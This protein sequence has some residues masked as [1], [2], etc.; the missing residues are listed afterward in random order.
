MGALPCSDLGEAGLCPRRVA[1]TRFA[2]NNEITGTNKPRT[3][4]PS[5]N[6][7]G[8]RVPENSED[9]P[10]ECGGLHPNDHTPDTVRSNSVFSS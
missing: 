9:V 8:I 2:P 7:Y 4:C 5:C 6:F 3:Y 1:S 10:D